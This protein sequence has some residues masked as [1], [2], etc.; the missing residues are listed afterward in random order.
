MPTI[1]VADDE[2]A[3]RLLLRTL[4]E[5]AG[6]LVIEAV[7]G[8]TAL[9]L[10][11]EAR[12]DLAIVDLHMPDANGVRLIEG[13]RADGALAHLAILLYTASDADAAMRDFMSRFRVC[14]VIPKPCE[15][16]ELLTIVA[17]ALRNERP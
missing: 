1:L 15:P 3:N 5:H 17:N 8:A 11:R 7:D 4:L 10:A 16:H 13:L 2:R 9:D 14:G 12:P 6:H